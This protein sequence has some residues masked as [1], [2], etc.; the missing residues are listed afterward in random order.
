[1]T[2]PRPLR[3]TGAL[4]TGG[5]G[6]FGRACALALARDGATVTLLGRTEET[7]RRAAAELTTAVPGADV[8]WVAGDATRAAD[9]AA[10]VARADRTPLRICVA[11][12]GGGTVRP[13]LGLEEEVLRG[14]FER[15]VTSALLAIRYAAAAMVPHGGGSVVCLSSSAAGGSFPFMPSYAVAKAALEALV[16]TA[17]DELGHLGVRVNAVRPGLVPTD[18]EKPG[19]LVA[20]PAQRAA[21]LAEKPL[22]RV[23]TVEDVAAAVRYLAGPESSWVTGAVLPVEGGNHL[24]RAPRLEALAR[25]I[26]GDETVDRALAGRL[27]D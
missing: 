1:M 2:E 10:A 14:D 17:A 3:G 18:A 7:L 6:G 13:L 4:V 8:D 27:P 22:A 23:G 9:V 11:T 12:V 20:D 25:A 5:A 15:N 26:C 16:R 19:M 24:R 21:V